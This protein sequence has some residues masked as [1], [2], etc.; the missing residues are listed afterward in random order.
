MRSEAGQA[1]RRDFEVLYADLA[2]GLQAKVLVDTGKVP[3]HARL[4]QGSDQIDLRV[5][6]LVRDPRAV[7][8]ARSRPKA[9]TGA[10]GAT[11]QM[12]E[13][14]AA[15][16]ALRWTLRNRACA[17]LAMTGPYALLRYETFAQYPAAAIQSTLSALGM[18][19]PARDLQGLQHRVFH[20]RPGIGF[21]GNPNRSDQGPVAIAPDL[22]WQTDLHW[23]SAMLVRALCLPVAGQ[24]P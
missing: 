1:Y 17:R 15:K 23:T 11:F 10:G 18:T 13:Q 8:H 22:R 4:L 3:F 19:V 6:H 16:V 5:L 20:R 12:R 14:S 7:A 21:S 2:R 24:W 9:A